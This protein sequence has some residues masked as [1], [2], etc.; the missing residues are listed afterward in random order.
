MTI[1][2]LRRAL[3]IAIRCSMACG[4]A[5]MPVSAA[6]GQ[7][8]IGYVSSKDADISGAADTIEGHAV[9]AGSAIITAKDH[10]APIT[11]SRGGVLRVCQTT[12]VHIDAGRSAQSSAP[13]M[14]SFDRG[15]IELQMPAIEPD[16]VITPDFRIGIRA[17]G[18]LDLQ[19][20]VARNG[21]TCVDN[22]GPQAPTLLF[23]DAL[24]VATYELLPGQHVL[25]EHGSLREVVDHERT[26]CGCP[27]SAGMSIADALLAAR[28]A[29]PSG[30]EEHPFPAALSEGL[31]PDA[32]PAAAV[33][34]SAPGETHTQIATSLTYS[35]PNASTTAGATAPAPAQNPAS[36]PSPAPQ[37]PT[38]KKHGVFHAVGHFFRKVFGGS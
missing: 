27:D 19:M 23:S 32:P 28:P 34:Q 2:T 1:R 33:P 6:V 8:L 30:T 22:R 4:L 31:T 9:L 10:T 16:V 36:T 3:A 26:P 25:F 15:A 38:A 14:L 11:L 12:A 7:Q 20:R 17:A 35:A 21:D 18:P 5:P 24:G 13:L 37:Q 29:A